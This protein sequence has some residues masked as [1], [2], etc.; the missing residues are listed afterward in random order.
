VP[1]IMRHNQRAANSTAVLGDVATGADFRR[2]IPPID[3]GAIEKQ[4]YGS[5]N[6]FNQPVEQCIVVRGSGPRLLLI[7][8]SHALGFSPAFAELARRRNLTF[9]IATYPSCPWPRGLVEEPVGSPT[10]LEQKCSARQD[11]WYRRLVPRFDPDVI[12]L[13]HHPFDDRGVGPDM[14]AN[15]ALIHPGTPAFASAVRAAARTTVDKLESGNRKIV[16]FEPLPL[17][18]ATFNPLTCLSAKKFLDDCR[19]VA[20]PTSP[21]ERFYRSLANGSNVFTLN[22]DRLVCPYFPICDPIV[23]G[24]VVKR[25]PQHITAAYAQF[26]AAPIGA[27]LVADGIISRSP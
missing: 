22:L 27:I 23:H 2:E 21:V 5:R 24:I 4:T 8:D 15:G 20:S 6:C 16:I 18:P 3:I 9:A 7:G 13:V 26:L 14:R 19:Y 10:D 17:A 11:D 1:G 25:D 12:V